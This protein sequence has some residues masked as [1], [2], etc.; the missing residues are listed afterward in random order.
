MQNVHYTSF[1]IS[2]NSM[3]GYSYYMMKYNVV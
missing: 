1:V 2:S 3:F